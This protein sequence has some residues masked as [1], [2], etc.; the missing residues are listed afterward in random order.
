MQSPA[1]SRLEGWYFY[2]QMRKFRNNSR[3]YHPRD[4]AGQTMAA[5]SKELSDGDIRDVVAYV[6]EN[7]GPVEAAS[8]RDKYLPA[9]SA[10]PF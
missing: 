3:G 2:E 10:K 7:F 4:L 6:V 9:R 1:L 5:A 8:Q